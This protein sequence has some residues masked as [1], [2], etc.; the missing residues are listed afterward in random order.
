MSNTELT[1]V[2][3][4]L[5]SAEETKP[6]PSI[7]ELVT[8]CESGEDIASLVPTTAVDSMKSFLI[9]YARSQLSRVLKLTEALQ[10]LEDSMIND[11]IT[12][13]NKYSPDQMIR[14]Y[15]TL[16]GSLNSALSLI[17][18]ISTD[19]TY[20]NVIVNNTTNNINANIN[21]VSNLSVV[22]LK[23][24]ESREKIRLVAS[25]LLARISE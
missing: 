24:Q 25:Q 23:S 7:S 13:M 9:V 19:D 4:D 6:M 8:M 16:H 18:M 11:A 1:T 10:T 3:T 20:Y 17:K 15:N 5:I 14:M 2:D 22:D 21:Q 12:N